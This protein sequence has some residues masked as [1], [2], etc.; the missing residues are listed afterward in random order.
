M[1]AV[2]NPGDV[3]PGFFGSKIYKNMRES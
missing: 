3:M 2:K 1:I